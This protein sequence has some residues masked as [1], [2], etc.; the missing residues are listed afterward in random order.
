MK[1]GEKTFIDYDSAIAKLK[2]Y[3]ME[4]LKLN[5][6]ASTRGLTAEEDEEINRLME[7]HNNLSDELRKEGYFEEDT[8]KR[9]L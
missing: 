9:S 5:K 7:A 4:I 3:E 2:Y 6:E 1:I 8:K